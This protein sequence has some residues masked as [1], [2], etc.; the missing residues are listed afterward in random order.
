MTA[1]ISPGTLPHRHRH[2]A[3]PIG[4][5]G[6]FREYADELAVRKSPIS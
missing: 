6:E 2:R 3:D 4:V 5:R 1:A